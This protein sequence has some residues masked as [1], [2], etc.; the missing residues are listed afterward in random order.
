MRL[1]KSESFC[2]LWRTANVSDRRLKLLVIEPN[3]ADLRWLEIA[4][5]DA[6][7]SHE[8]LHFD[9][10]VQAVT[11]LR[12]DSDVRVDLVL[13]EF[14]LPFLTPTEA[15]AR[16][17]ALP[18]FATVPIVIAIADEREKRDVYGTPHFVMKPIEADQLLRIIEPAQHRTAATGQYA[19]ELLRS[20]SASADTSATFEPE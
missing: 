20:R 19:A 1:P 7:V 5:D 9:S 17:R 11:T 18:Q 10:A 8:L 12:T 6:G 16:L 14:G 13:M 2:R 4:L 15:V 3:P